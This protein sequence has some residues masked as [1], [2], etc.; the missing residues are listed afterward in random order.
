MSKKAGRFS[1]LIRPLTACIDLVIINVLA[2]VWFSTISEGHYLFHLIL[3]LGWLI[4]AGLSDYYEVYRHTKTVRVA[5]KVW[6]QFTFQ[7]VLVA[8]Y[9]G[10]FDRFAEVREL[11]GYGVSIFAI[12]CTIKFTIFFLLK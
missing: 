7:F 8:S 12:I 10:L 3:S 2:Q 11:V 9:N 4:A 1:Y 5:E 6:K